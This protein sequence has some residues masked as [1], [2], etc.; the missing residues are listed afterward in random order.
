MKHL[1]KFLFVLPLLS[2]FFV[3]SAGS[4]AAQVANCQYGST[5]ARVHKDFSDPWKQSMRINLGEQFE[6]GGFHDHTGQFGSDVVIQ[7][8]GPDM[9][10]F[11]TN[12]ERITPTKAGEYTVYVNTK[13][14]F[15]NGC[16]Q[17]A[18][19]TVVAPP[20]CT[21]NST[22]ARV[23][24]DGTQP[25]RSSL[26]INKNESFRVGSFHN[27]SDQFAGDTSLVVTGPA[28]PNGVV[29]G[30]STT[31]APGVAGRYVLQV[32]T[33]NQSGRRCQANAYI[34]VRE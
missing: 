3:F 31:L 5:Q 2:G 4:V 33:N 14:R 10:K 18:R 21:Y 26:T 29:A 34:R 23:Q 8:A 30:N 6:A 12:G 13:D 20:T 9:L 32:T 16:S 17:Q 7:V 28:F 15:G 1:L 24:R 27:R 22:Q 25:W 19:V 11:V